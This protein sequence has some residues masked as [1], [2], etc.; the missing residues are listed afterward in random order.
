MKATKKSK[1]AAKKAVKKAKPK[2]AAKKAVKKAKP[3]KAVK[4]AKPKKAAKKPVKKAKPKKAA[5]KKPVKKAKPKKAAPKKPV[6]KAKPKKAVKKA[7]PVKAKPAALKAPMPAPK[8]A[9]PRVEQPKPAPAEPAAQAP[10]EPA[11]KGSDKYTIDVTEG[12]DKRYFVLT[13]NNY[14]N[15]FTLD[16]MKKVVNVCH[17][18]T[19]ERDGMM[20][21]YNWFKTFRND[22]IINTR[23]EG[24]FDPALTT[25][26]KY[27]VT[28]YSVKD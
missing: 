20:R 27:L 8:P 14:R 23:I 7:S 3:K 25:I 24:S 5:P 2:K 28:T 22:V 16:E 1:P 10:G 15:F 11:R 6:K 12:E 4:K 26:Y 18:A 9:V 13:V 21:L 17:E 19:D